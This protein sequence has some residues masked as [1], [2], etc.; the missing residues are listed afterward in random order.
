VSN[1]V[2]YI[3]GGDAQSLRLYN[4][5]DRK[6]ETILDSLVSYDLAAGGEKLIARIG[7]NYSIVAPKPGQKAGE[8]QL[9]L[10]NMEMRID[11]RAEWGDFARGDCDWFTTRTCTARLE[12]DRTKWPA[13]RSCAPRRLDYI[14]GELRRIERGTCFV[15]RQPT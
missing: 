9:K 2:L 1:G 4:I 5:D 10:D 8:S 7:A 3:K 6:E 12:R 14:L 13:V 15:V 11:P